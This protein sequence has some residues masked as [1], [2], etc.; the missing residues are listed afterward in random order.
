MGRQHQQYIFNFANGATTS[1]NQHNL[2]SIAFGTLLVP[3]DFNAKTCNFVTAITGTPNADGLTT[4]SDFN[5]KTLLS[6][7]KTLATGS[8]ALTS[9]EIR[10][11]MPA[12][13]VKMTIS[14]AATGAQ[15]AVL[16][17]K[18]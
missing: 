5:T 7:A 12:G 10:E 16:W 6:A 18:D 2:G 11:L 15:Q 13:P 9:D 17:G 3:S 8:N 4:P 1:T 14:A